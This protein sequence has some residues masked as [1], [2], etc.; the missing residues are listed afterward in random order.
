MQCVQ[1]NG[2]NSFTKLCYLFTYRIKKPYSFFCVWFS[3]ILYLSSIHG[4]YEFRLLEVP[5]FKLN[6]F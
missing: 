6:K 2:D 4:I 1:I 3:N 5:T